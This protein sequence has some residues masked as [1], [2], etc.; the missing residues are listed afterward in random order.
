M[1]LTLLLEAVFT[2]VFARVLI[3]YVRRPDPLQQRVTMMFSSL[4]VLFVLDV[5]R[6][7]VGQPPP[8]LSALAAALLLGQPFLT[9]HVVRPV[10]TVPTWLYRA[11]FAGWALSTAVLLG[12]G[13][14]LGR[15]QVILVVCVFVGTEVCAAHCLARLARQRVGAS[16]MRLRLAAAATV[17]FAAAILVAGAGS[18]MADPESVRRASQLIAL[19]SAIGYMLAFVPPVFVRRQWSNRAAYSVVRSL[20]ECPAD[21]PPEQIWSRY[22]DAVV[23]ATGAGG[24]VVLACTP[25]NGVRE[26]TRLN[27]PALDDGGADYAAMSRLRGTHSLEPHSGQQGPL[28]VAR[29]Y[30]AAVQARFVTVALVQLPAAEG[31]LLLFNRFRSLFTDDD[32]QLLGDVGAQAATLAERAELLAERDRLT[33][34]LSDSVTALTAAT[35]AKSDFMA[36]MSHELRTPLSAIIGFSG[37]MRNEPVVDDQTTVPTEWI[38]H[39]HSS[40]QH[41]VGLV[42][43]VLDLSKIEAGK[44]DLNRQPLD[45]AEAIDEVVTSLTS[46]TQAKQLDVTVAV[47]PLRVDADPVR[48]RQIV[49][50]LLS[51]AV[52]FT[53]EGGRIFLAARRAGG[54]IALSVADSGPGISATDQQRVFD[55]FHQ[56]GDQAS[57]EGGTGL[58]LALTRRLAHAHGGRIELESHLGHGSKFTVWLPTADH[59]TLEGTGD[60]GGTGVLIVEDDPGAAQ[61]LSTYLT[62]AGYQVTVAATGEQGLATARACAPEAILLD[63]RLPGIDGW[64]V[65]ADIKQDCRLSHIPVVVVSVLDDTEVAMALGAVDYFIKPVEPQALLSWLTRN[66]L[67]PP[68][69]GH[70]LTVLAID[71]DP[72]SRQL[73]QTSLSQHSMQVVCAPGGVQ[74]LRMA[75]QHRYDL[76][77]CDLLMPDIDGFDVVAALREHPTTR[78]VPVLVLTAKTLTDT[79]KTRL[80]GKVAAVACKGGPVDGLAAL[81]DTIDRLTGAIPKKESVTT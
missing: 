70:D 44:I 47:P 31:V 20:L 9:L 40:G 13:T 59:H 11:A 25:D 12:S 71:D 32:V 14:V 26:V 3:G 18:A 15:A 29:F 27:V 61:L 54:Y 1:A 64:Q 69:T 76:I 38:G 67:V 77:I 75:R 72:A 8:W 46:L 17:A 52:K 53:P 43:E 16:R 36:N 24:A 35:K 65:L 55:E 50:N 58:G 10:G 68:M 30:G 5:L 34:E 7:T 45:V 74:G 51:N 60:P 2:G 49:T 63:I 19:L 22:A 73:I 33:T 80:N 66:G 39:I 57:R 21:A 48:L 28:A 62:K 6:Q 23:R 81:T 78:D 56:A 37:L 42:N 4:A 79:D 41:L